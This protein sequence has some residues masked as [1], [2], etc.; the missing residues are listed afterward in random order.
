MKAWLR[1]T[2]FGVKDDKGWYGSEL[3]R[4][5]VN[6]A[7]GRMRGVLHEGLIKLLVKNP[8]NSSKVMKIAL[9]RYLYE[10]FTVLKSWKWTS[11]GYY[12]WILEEKRRIRIIWE[13]DS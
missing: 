8:R 11:E 6:I 1:Y 12:T 4:E 9:L 3:M 5:R 7:S 10:W 13:N 2:R